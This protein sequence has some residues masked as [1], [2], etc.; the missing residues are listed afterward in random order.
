MRAKHPVCAKHFGVRSIF[1][2]STARQG[3]ALALLFLAAILAGCGRTKPM[4]YYDISYPPVGPAS[5][6]PVNAS[7][8]VQ[9]FAASDLYR[10]SR[11]VYGSAG[12]ELGTYQNELWAEAPVELLRDALVRGLR[13]SQ[14]FR[15]VMTY[16]SD[17]RGDFLVTG[18]LYEFREVDGNPIVARL[19]FEVQLRD[20]KAAKTIWN[21]SYKHDEPASGKSISAVVEAMSHNVQRSVQEVEAGIQQALSTYAP[22]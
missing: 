9:R 14:R 3:T 15:S 22:K 8:L 1:S 7:L 13:S 16:R 11:I 17:S 5:Q 20:I 10:D 19:V 4:K 18:H 6:E 21:F 12:P 2:R